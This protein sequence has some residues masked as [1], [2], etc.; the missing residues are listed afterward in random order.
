MDFIDYFPLTGFLLMLVLITVRIYSLK[1]K[2]IQ[3]ISSSQKNRSSKVLYP[4]FVFIFLLWL[5]EIVRPAFR[6]SFSLLPEQLTKQIFDCFS[7]KTTGA[8]LILF[9]LIFWI[10]TL[11]HFQNSL[12]LGL[13]E[14]NK[15]TLITNGI[16]SLSRNPFFLSFDL[17]FLGVALILPSVFMLVFTIAALVSIHFFI[18][19]EERFMTENYGEEYQNYRQKTRRYL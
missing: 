6:I 9:A 13:N 14:N 3:V 8:I 12:R 2:R 1:Q 17:Y 18:L 4:I 16:F 15:G 10:L 11:S 7:V 19:K 5:F